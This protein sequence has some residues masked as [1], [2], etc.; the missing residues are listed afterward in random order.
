[1]Y[2]TEYTLFLE[3]IIFLDFFLHCF[4][5]C[6]LLLNS[7]PNYENNNRLVF[8]EHRC[9]RQ[10]LT[11]EN[12]IILNSDKVKKTFSVMRHFEIYAEI[13]WNVDS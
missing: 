5:L 3:I 4:Y 9:S 11:E 6:N 8:Q 2:V 10:V 1:M 7:F 12:S 13:I